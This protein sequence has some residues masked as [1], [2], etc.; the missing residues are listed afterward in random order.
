MCT[1]DH[2]LFG[3][4]H[5]RAKSISQEEDSA[6]QIKKHMLKEGSPKWGRIITL[7]KV[8]QI[9]YCIMELH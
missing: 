3:G 6:M 8:T 1:R 7:L 4:N 9:N 2:K 5:R